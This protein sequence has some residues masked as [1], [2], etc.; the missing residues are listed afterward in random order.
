MAEEVEALLSALA[1]RVLG[2]R[3]VAV[4]PLPPGLGLRRFFRIHLAGATVARCVARVEA[5]EDPTGRPAGAAPEPPLEPLRALLEAAGLPVPA[6]YGAD[7]EGRIA[8]LEDV[9]DRSLRSVAPGLAP[10]GREALYRQACALVPR[11]QRIED[12]GDGRVAAFGRRLDG[13]QLAYKAG[14]FA[15]WSL[16]QALGRPARPAEREVVRKAFAWIADAVAAAPARLAHRDYQSMNLHL[17]SEAA[18]GAE[19]VLLDLQGAWL[20]PPEYDLVC[21]LRDSYVELPDARVRA[22]AEA[23]RADLPD[24]PEPDTFW[25]RFDLLTL[26]RKGKDH[27]LFHY[28][29]ADRGERSWLRSVPAT[30]RALQAAARRTASLDPRLTRLAELVLALPEAPCAR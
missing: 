28:V 3:V 11:L 27:A 30:T 2:G 1:A 13:A 17:R 14:R 5:A 24:A 8:L 6:R 21:L 16:P 12:P 15:D 26:A 7:A 25:R 20:A 29:A 22:L 9:G 10:E 4:E 23:V 18:P 19:L